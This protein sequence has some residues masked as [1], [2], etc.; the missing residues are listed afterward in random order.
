M[1]TR[2]IM[3]RRVGAMAGEKVAL[4]ASVAELLELARKRAR[5]HLARPARLLRAR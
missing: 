3:L 4:P 1:L 5:P 2:I